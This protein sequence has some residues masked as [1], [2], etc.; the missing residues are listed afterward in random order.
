MYLPTIT[1]SVLVCTNN[2]SA[3]PLKAAIQLPSLETRSSVP[4]LVSAAWWHH[5]SQKTGKL[6]SNF[7]NPAGL[8]FLPQIRKCFITS[9]FLIETKF[10]L[11]NWNIKIGQVISQLKT[12]IQNPFIDSSIDMVNHRFR[13]SPNT[14]SSPKS[15]RLP[16]TTKTQAF[17]YASLQK[18]IVHF[19]NYAV[20]YLFNGFLTLFQNAKP[21]LKPFPF[22]PYEIIRVDNDPNRLPYLDQINRR[23]YIEI[24][25]PLDENVWNLYFSTLTKLNDPTNELTLDGTTIVYNT[26]LNP[27]NDQLLQLEHTIDVLNELLE[28]ASATLQDLQHHVLPIYAHDYDDLSRIVDEIIRSQNSPLFN[29]KQMLN[30]LRTHKHTFILRDNCTSTVPTSTCSM[31]IVTYLPIINTQHCYQQYEVQTFP[32]K[33]PGLISDDWIQIQLPD[34]HFL[35][36][37]HVVKVIDPDHHQC[38]ENENNFLELCITKKAHIQYPSHCFEKILSA[39]TLPETL[40]QCSYNKLSHI[41]NQATFL[42]SDSLA[43]I[44]P[45]PGTIIT[46]CPGQEAQTSQ[47]QQ[48]GILHMDPTCAYE[49]VNGPLSPE[50]SYHP[51]LTITNLAESSSIILHDPNSQ[52]IIT[53]HVQEYAVHYISGLASSVA[54]L[55]S[56]FIIYCSYGRYIPCCSI[57]FRR[58]QRNISACRP[59][60][61]PRPSAPMLSQNEPSPADIRHQLQRMVR[62]QL[63]ATVI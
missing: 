48:T 14:P 22:S 60:P 4:Y 28:D 47:L 9:H 12:Y 50:D 56:M 3:Y 36:N 38:L 58:Q 8:V 59:N 62:H 63:A 31:Y 16:K 35:L 42:D 55:L 5:S 10:D 54:L 27:F 18:F 61:P 2:S 39:K 33:K 52:E 24:S 1:I 21:T 19:E 49:M 46:R 6:I 57:C 34:K 15:P 44:N 43:Y 7:T 53:H 40:K 37:E 41:T 23:A 17:T 45:N 20:P 30:Y 32:V 51:F 25:D 11:S 26:S 13:R 29:A